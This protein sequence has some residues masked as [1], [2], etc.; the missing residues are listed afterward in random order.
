MSPYPP[1]FFE[2]N[3]ILRK[4][5]KSQLAQTIIVY[6][7]KSPSCEATSDDIGQTEKYV[8]DGGS[9]LNQ[10]KW[11]RGDT[12]STIANTYAAFTSKHYGSAT[13]VWWVCIRSVH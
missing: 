11:M 9:L 1:S 4:A 3:K 12:Y 13:V 6:C 8:L 7:N 5:D 2:D 10:L